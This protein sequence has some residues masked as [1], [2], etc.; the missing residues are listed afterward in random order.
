MPASLEAMEIPPID[1]WSTGRP[2][3]LPTGLQ[4]MVSLPP[5]W[6]SV[7]WLLNEPPV[8]KYSVV[9]SDPVNGYV[10]VSSKLPVPRS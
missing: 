4:S 9:G 8:P 10:V 5:C 6:R 3:T 1:H 2:Q 7:S